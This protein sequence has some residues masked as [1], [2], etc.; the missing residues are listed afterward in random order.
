MCCPHPVL[1]CP[2]NKKCGTDY[3]QFL[4]QGFGQNQPLKFPLGRSTPL[5]SPHW[6]LLRT[7][8]PDELNQV[9]IWSHSWFGPCLPRIRET[10][11]IA[12]MQLYPCTSALWAPAFAQPDYAIY[13]AKVAAVNFNAIAQDL[14]CARCPRVVDFSNHVANDAIGLKR[15]SKNKEICKE[16]LCFTDVELEKTSHRIYEIFLIILV[17]TYE[18]SSTMEK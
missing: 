11:C 1:Y 10:R 14:P 7:P 9:M 17:R 12:A 8:R 3:S 13:T 16:I 2:Q 5:R 18:Y 4:K 15:A 6:S